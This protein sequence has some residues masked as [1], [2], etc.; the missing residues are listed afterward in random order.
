MV[1]RGVMATF[2]WRLAGEPPGTFGVFAD[3]PD[4]VIFA[5]AVAWMA[6]NEIT[7]GASP[8]TFSPDDLVNRAQV[9]TFIWRLANTA[10]A[11]GSGVELPETVTF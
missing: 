1:S 4:N 5:R 8:T 2:L 11:W 10:G 6:D 7:T 3:V 9:I